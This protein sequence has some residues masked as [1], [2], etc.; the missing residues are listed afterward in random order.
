MVK[1]IKKLIICIFF[2]LVFNPFAL[3]DDSLLDDDTLFEE[4][5]NDFDSW[6]DDND[7]FGDDEINSTRI[8]PWLNIGVTQKWGFNPVSD[9]STTK[10]RTELTFGTTGSISDA[11]YSE[12]ELKAT[13]YW[14][15]DSYHL[16][17]SSDVE[18]E[19]AFLQFSFDRWSAK[20][21]RYTIGWG[22]LEG[23]VLDVVNPS[24]GLT[25]PS[26]TSQWLISATRYGDE[27]DI[28]VFYNPKPSITNSTLVALKDDR[29]REF[30]LRYGINREGSDMAFYAGQLIP[31]DAIKN[32]TDGLAYA[33]PYQLF[34]FG[35]NK[36]FNDYLLKFDI[37][38]KRN[39][40]HNRLGQFVKA[41]RMD[42]DLA[43]DITEGDRQWLFSIN[44]QYW[45]DFFNDYLTTTLLSSV[46]SEK[47]SM[48]YMANV[49]DKIGET[50]WSWN[51]SNIVAANNDLSLIT[52]GLDWDISDNLN[53]KLTAT[54]AN[55]KLDRAFSLLD[56]Y[57]RVNLEVKFQY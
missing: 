44:S 54:K 46:S 42:W 35:M 14:P 39:L 8:F 15:S 22:E 4:T 2:C 16:T 37:A 55:A 10:E 7:L 49:S 30:G 11:V 21:G 38:Y 20:L 1:L 18:I 52:A 50:D 25:D 9:W 32:L 26:I 12:L 29:H 27:S 6:S 45:L 13:K 5:D 56:N 47:N 40:Q 3:A 17:K 53:A 43:F 24:G 48:T 34:G 19:R 23:G 36:V 28:S 41:D 51:L 31:N 33:S 57:Q